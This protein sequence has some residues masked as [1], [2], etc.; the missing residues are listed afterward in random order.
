MPITRY[1]G[2]KS[3]NH[4]SHICYVITS[5]IYPAHA[6]TPKAPKSLINC[7]TEDMLST[8]VYFHFIV[9]IYHKIRTK[10]EQNTKQ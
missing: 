7:F 3:K 5:K 9:F 4:Q 2:S 8:P 10:Q 1:C 6:K